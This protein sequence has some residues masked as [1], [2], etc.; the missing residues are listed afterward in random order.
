MA[1]PDA[2]TRPT[3]GPLSHD[4][5]ERL[6]GDERQRLRGLLPVC[7]D[8]DLARAELSSNGLLGPVRSVLALATGDSEP[9]HV[10][11]VWAPDVP[12]RAT[13]LRVA[14]AAID[15]PSTDVSPDDAPALAAVVDHVFTRTAAVR[16]EVVAVASDEASRDLCARA[17]LP[18]EGVRRAALVVGGA[19]RDLA[20]YAVVRAGWS[21]R[22]A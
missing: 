4:V 17:G 21:R 8:P 7:A 9:S 15:R 22:R 20:V 13:T 10:A 6:L 16:V 3:V 14:L 5:L 18:L 12:A 19:P 11:E 1:E 2:T